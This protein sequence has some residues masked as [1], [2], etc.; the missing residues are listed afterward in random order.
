[1]LRHMRDREM[2]R[3]NVIENVLRSDLSA[4]E[5]AHATARCRAL[6]L[7]DE[8]ALSQANIVA[9]IGEQL[10][11]L[12]KDVSARQVYR[13]LRMADVMTPEVIEH[14]AIHQHAIRALDLEAL[15]A[16]V[17]DAIARGVGQVMQRRRGRPPKSAEQRQ[18]DADRRITDKRARLAGLLSDP[19]LTGGSAYMYHEILRDDGL[20]VRCWTVLGDLGALPPTEAVALL[21]DLKAPQKVARQIVR[22]DSAGRSA[23]DEAQLDEVPG[24]PG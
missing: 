13:Y 14:Q 18:A 17:S 1:V 6:V 10:A 11:G 5:W 4:W 16:L 3:L 9:R 7:A 2:F 21:A 19:A 23:T 12:G 22:R 24:L 15:D 20:L 8:P